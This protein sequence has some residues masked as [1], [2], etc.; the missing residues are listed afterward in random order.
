MKSS[1][2]TLWF[3]SYQSKASEMVKMVHNTTAF[4][5]SLSPAQ[6][7]VNNQWIFSSTSIFSFRL[8]KHWDRGQ[9]KFWSV[10]LLSLFWWSQVNIPCDSNLINQR[11]A[12]WSRRST[13]PLPSGKTFSCAKTS[14]QSVNVLQ[15]FDFQ[16]LA[17][18]ALRQGADKILIKYIFLFWYLFNVLKG[19]VNVASQGELFLLRKTIS[20]NKMK[21]KSGFTDLS[22]IPQG[23]L[24]A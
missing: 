11:R 21:S 20:I 19:E 16:L 24:C 5:G 1:E 13:T 6:R 9:T 14:Q 17:G 12:R 4:W 10:P 2:Y 8:E 15:Y 7:Q 3:Q 23:C 22:K 18:K